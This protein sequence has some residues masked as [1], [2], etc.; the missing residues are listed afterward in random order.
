[1][2]WALLHIS[3]VRPNNH[4]SGLFTGDEIQQRDDWNPKNVQLE[5]GFACGKGLMR[6]WQAPD[7]RMYL[8][9]GYYA[10]AMDPPMRS[11][12]PTTGSIMLHCSLWVRRPQLRVQQQLMRHETARDL[13]RANFP[14]FSA[15][16]YSAPTSLT[17]QLGRN[18]TPATLPVSVSLHLTVRV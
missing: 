17:C 2:C 15:V 1:M 18:G 9:V 6:Y 12:R 8:I 11:I 7:P 3:R 13:A 4:W 10:H 16:I 14:R 5:E